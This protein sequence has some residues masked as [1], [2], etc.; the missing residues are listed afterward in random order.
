MES[1][2]SEIILSHYPDTIAIYLFGS[3][4]DSTFN[5]K[6]DLDLGVLFSPQSKNRENLNFS[7][8]HFS[9]EQ[10]FLLSVDLINLRAV[11]T[12]MQ[13]EVIRYNKRIYCSNIYEA[14]TFEMLTLSYYGKLN[15]ERAGILKQ[16][17][18]TGEIINNG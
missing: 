9:L 12:V 18:Q 14:D 7:D 10:Q 2:I 11:D 15:E 1:K 16:I 3:R 6:S 13:K 5:E 4:A 17:R 8:A